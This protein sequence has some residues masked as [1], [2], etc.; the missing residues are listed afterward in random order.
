M[1]RIILPVVLSCFISFSFGQSLKNANKYFN[2]KDF[3]KAKSEI[4]GLLAKT[5]DDGEAIYLKSKIYAKI[6]DSAALHPLVEGDARA[7][8]FDAFKKAVADSANMKLKLAI[9]KDNYGP[10]FDMYTGYYQAGIDDFNKAAQTKSQ[11]EFKNA[12]NN[13]ILANN[14][15]S[16]IS[17][18]DWAK[19][20][21]VDTTLVL[22]IGKAAINAKDDA[23]TIEYFTQLADNKIAGPAGSNDE[24]FKLPYEWLEQHYKNADDEANMLK[25]AKLGNEVY[26]KEPY[27]N[28]VLIDYYREKKNPPK[29]LG[30]YED[31][32]MANPDSIKYHF[33]YANDIF[34][35]LY[36]SDE[37]T[38]VENRDQWMKALKTQLDEAMALNSNDINTNWLTSQYYYNLGIESRDSAIKAKDP[39]IKANL[40]ATAKDDWNKSIP[41][42]EKAINELK[43]SGQKANKSRYK[44]VVN[45][46]QNIY[47]SMDDKVNLKKYQDMYDGADSL[48]DNFQS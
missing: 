32:V 46:M 41:F 5:P 27:F 37:G 4:D 23:K 8:A 29:M 39:T 1:K 35:Y 7:I 36:N 2:N 18:N 38:K 13:F 21:K 40:N 26:P 43:K 31:L 9:M 15:G 25:Y 17:A 28:L 10:V 47:Q 45:L 34:G 24:G 44:S 14:V 16:Y 48:F 11:D 22:N 3:E 19:I 12:M 42:A 20:G 33:G 6:A 30:A